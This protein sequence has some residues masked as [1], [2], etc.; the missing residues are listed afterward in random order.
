MSAFEDFARIRNSFSVFVVST[1]WLKLC[2]FIMAI[3]N[4]A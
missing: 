1:G 3:Y 2:V 4:N